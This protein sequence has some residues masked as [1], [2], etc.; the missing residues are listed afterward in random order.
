MQ[1]R[2]ALLLSLKYFISNIRMF[3]YFKE[4][5]VGMF[6]YWEVLLKCHVTL[7]KTIEDRV[8]VWD[9]RPEIGDIF[10]EKVISNE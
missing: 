2:Q 3:Y 4:M 10:I 6:S 8:K 5:K 9:Q 1:K 7:L